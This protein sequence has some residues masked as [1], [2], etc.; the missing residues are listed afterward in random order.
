MV[1]STFAS[2]PL[3]GPPTG[4]VRRVSD[5]VLGRI[6]SGAYPSGLRLPSEIDLAAELD[7]GRSTVREALRH[8]SALG[9]V[10]SRR[11]SGAMVLDFR[12]EGT[13]ALLP[14]YIM[15]GRFDRP[16]EALARELLGVRAMLAQ[17]AVR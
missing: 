4:E 5:H 2:D 10:K 3:R 15:N 9:V 12:R 7:C 14:L 1:P 13:P 11:G 17:E 8:L 16:V 6:I